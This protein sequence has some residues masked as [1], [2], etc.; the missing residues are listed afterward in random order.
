MIMFIKDV[1]FYFDK[2]SKNKNDYFSSSKSIPHK[3]LD[4]ENKQ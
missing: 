4:N 1:V 3:A 2:M